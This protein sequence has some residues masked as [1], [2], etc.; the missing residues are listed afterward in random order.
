[1]L[2]YQRIPCWPPG[3]VDGC[4][5]SWGPGPT[6]SFFGVGVVGSRAGP[7]GLP[8]YPGGLEHELMV[9]NGVLMVFNDGYK[10]LVVT[11]T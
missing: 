10:W 5:A 2:V 3:R 7:E 8:S 11:G 6:G 4:Q 1:M 9:F